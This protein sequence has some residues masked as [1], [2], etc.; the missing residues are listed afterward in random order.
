VEQ[1]ETTQA[2]QASELP[3]T[4]FPL[5]AAGALAGLLIAAGIGLRS[6]GRERRS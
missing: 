1:T 5:W 2:T 6:V 4:G 3:F